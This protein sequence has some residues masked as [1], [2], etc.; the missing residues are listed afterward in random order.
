MI[1]V[2]IDYA[3]DDSGQLKLWAKGTHEP[4]AF[5]PACEKALFEWDHRKVSLA[6]KPVVHA[7]WR[8]VKANAESNTACDF[9]R[10]ES[11]PGRGAYAVT[12]LD[13]WLPIGVC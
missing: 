3:S 13:D 11:E 9:V 8:T 10:K 1:D 6:G 12:V 7:H 4:A 5:L 2:Q